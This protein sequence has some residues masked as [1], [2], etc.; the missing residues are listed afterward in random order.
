MT[1]Y[2]IKGTNKADWGAM[3]LKLITSASPSMVISNFEK[4]GWKCVTSATYHA[5]R[6]RFSSSN[7]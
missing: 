4:K 5:W 2:F 7:S 3:K 6:K 1:L